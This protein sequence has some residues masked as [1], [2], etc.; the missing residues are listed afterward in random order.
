MEKAK[1]TR[2]ILTRKTDKIVSKTKPLELITKPKYGI[3]G[4]YMD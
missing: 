3:N 4:K 1:T 2:K